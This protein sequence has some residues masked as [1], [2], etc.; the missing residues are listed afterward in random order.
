MGCGVIQ[1]PKDI[2]GFVERKLSLPPSGCGTRMCPCRSGCAQGCP[3]CWVLPCTQR[4][5]MEMCQHRVVPLD[6]PLSSIPCCHPQGRST[7]WYLQITWLEGQHGS[8]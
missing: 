8:K 2:L 5:H 3:E 1:N 6:V 4:S 7:L